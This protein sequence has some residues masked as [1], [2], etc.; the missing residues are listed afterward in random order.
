[1]ERFQ[2]ASS[3]KAHGPGR[4]PF[5]EQEALDARFGEVVDAADSAM[6]AL[7]EAPAPDL[8]ALA[9]K[10]SLIADHLVWELEGGE[11]C[12]VWLEADVRRLARAAKA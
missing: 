1:M 3:A 12:L 2:E 11:E 6:L 10:I 8:E 7:L 4:R 5:E 9:V